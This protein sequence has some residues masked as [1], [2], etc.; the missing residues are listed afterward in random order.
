MVVFFRTARSVAARY[1][2]RYSVSQNLLDRNRVLSII[3]RDA[4][5]SL[6]LADDPFVRAWMTDEDN[7]TLRAPALQ[8]LESY[9]SLFRDRSYFVGV[10]ESLSYYVNTLETDGTVHTVLDPDQPHDRWFFE[11]LASDRDFWINVDFNVLLN[12]IRVWINTLVRT[13]EGELLGAAGTG[14]DVSDFLAALAEQELPGISTVV[15]NAEGQ[16][17]AHR[18]REIIE[19]NARVTRNEDR[20]NLETLI[21]DATDRVALRDMLDQL[22]TAPPERPREQVDTVTLKVEG[23]PVTAAVGYIPE[24]DWFNLVLVEEGAV[25]GPAEFFPFIA[26]IL[27]S[28]IGVLGVVVVLLN[29]LVLVPLGRLD[30]AANQVARGSY[31]VQLAGNRN[32]E[33]G[34]LARSFTTMSAEI[35]RYTTELE[36]MVEERTRELHDSRERILESIRYGSLIQG[37][38]MPPEAELRHHLRESYLLQHPLDEVG[39]DFAW[40]HPLDDGFCVAVV[41]CTGH[42][43]PGAFMTMLVSAVLNRV[44]ATIGSETTPAEMLQQVHKHVQDGLRAGTETEHLDNGLDIALCRFRATPGG[45]GEIDFSGAGIPLWYRDGQGLHR[46]PGARVRLGFHSTERHPEIPVHRVAVHEN[47][48]YYLITDG[49]LDL[50]GGQ[51]GYGLGT[52]GFE[53]ILREADGRAELGVEAIK[54]AL[55]AYQGSY[56]ARDDLL[57]WAFTPRTA[58][59][60][61]QKEQKP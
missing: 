15:V 42:G 19:H 55:V 41:D 23:T 31:D 50:P 32:D 26:L 47:S 6:K 43:V 3:D 40:F 9:R 59:E 28:L 11:T 12:E 7:P 52:R 45:N 18:D 57:L 10:A 2:E 13:G 17:L 60:F 4:T 34:R 51:H 27:V 44:V 61:P 58:G 49:V 22:R 29:R 21:T 8:Q 33:I 36:N 20:I 37:S 39:G 56:P 1:V 46:I 14:M 30:H 16:I 5:L 54:A 25:I 48:V 38:I 35:R 24:L 53:E